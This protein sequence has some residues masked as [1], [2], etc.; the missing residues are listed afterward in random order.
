[1]NIFAP[2][3]D[4]FTQKNACPLKRKGVHTDWRTRFPFTLTRL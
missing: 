2:L 1:M 4:L 3:P